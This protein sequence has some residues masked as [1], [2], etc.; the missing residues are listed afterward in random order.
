[1]SSK[2]KRSRRSALSSPC[3]SR[4]PSTDI[5]LPPAVGTTA[6]AADMSDLDMGQLRPAGS[7]SVQSANQLHEVVTTCEKAVMVFGFRTCSHALSVMDMQYTLCMEL[8]KASCN[9]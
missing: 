5:R 3:L 7:R 8:N 2:T 9:D 1:M 4:L 6:V